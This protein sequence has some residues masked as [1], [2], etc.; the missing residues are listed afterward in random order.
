MTPH[1]F[2]F[3][4]RSR[5]EL[6]QSGTCHN[7]TASHSLSVDS[8]FQNESSLSK[9]KVLHC[10]FDWQFKIVVFFLFQFGSNLSEANASIAE[11]VY[12]NNCKR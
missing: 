1:N 12:G 11:I 4:P 10:A 2:H 9:Q 5:P 6:S 8:F 7:S 3:V